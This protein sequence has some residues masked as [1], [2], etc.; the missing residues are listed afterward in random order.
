MICWPCRANGLIGESPVASRQP[1][2]PTKEGL[3]LYWK[4]FI[5]PVRLFSNLC[6]MF[7]SLD[8]FFVLTLAFPPGC[9]YRNESARAAFTFRYLNQAFLIPSP[10]TISRKQ[11]HRHLQVFP[12][13]ANAIFCHPSIVDPQF[14]HYFGITEC[15][16]M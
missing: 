1:F 15:V 7:V 9:S 13:H 6:W 8:C 5:R 10:L 14:C 4:T 2:S 11:T 16:S 12:A 3:C